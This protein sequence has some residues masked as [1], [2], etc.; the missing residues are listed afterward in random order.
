MLQFHKRLIERRLWFHPHG[1]KYPIQS[2]LFCFIRDLVMHRNSTHLPVTDNFRHFALSEECNLFVR[3]YLLLQH[4]RTAQFIPAMD[5]IHLLTDICKVKCIFKRHIATSDNRYGLVLEKSTITCRTIRYPGSGKRLLSRYSELTVCCPC[6]KQNGF[7]L[8]VVAIGHMKR[9]CCAFCHN[10]FH[11]TFCECNV[12]ISCMLLK[13]FCQFESAPVIQSQI[14]IH[15]FRIDHLSAGHRLLLDH[16][17]RK[18]RP[19]RIDRCRKS[20]RSAS[21]DYQIVHFVLL[22]SA[23]ISLISS[24]VTCFSRSI[25]NAFSTRFSGSMSD[26]IR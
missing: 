23:E 11:F 20:R 6:R 7:R 13:R 16:K 8:N 22:Y 26:R 5:Q 21:Y 2:N 3:K 10:F 9:P 1:N 25:S 24:T 12:K 4:L 17:D 14:I 15:F 18:T 19:L